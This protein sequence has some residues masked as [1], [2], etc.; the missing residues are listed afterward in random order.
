MFQMISIKRPVM[1]Q[2]LLS[3]MVWALPLNVIS[4]DLPCQEIEVSQSI[5]TRAAS[6]SLFDNWL[7][8]RGTVR[9]ESQLM[10]TQ[11]QQRLRTLLI[12]PKGCPKPCKISEKPQMTFESLP[13]KI[14]QGYS[15]SEKCES[16]F[17]KSKQDP[18]T[19]EHNFSA[20]DDLVS[21]VQELS[22]GNGVDGEDLY[23]RCDG[24]CSPRYYYSIDL[25]SRP[26]SIKAKI[27]CG[28]ARDKSENMYNISFGFSWICLS[29]GE[30]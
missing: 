21:W 12:P 19:Y 23:R 28:H 30:G 4:A 25:V 10:F 5:E 3:V 6:A 29:Q 7:N 24:A 13:S 9:R 16:Y 26:F 27:I 14:L 15:D 20:V 11:A 18:I 1:S 17:Q 8:L 22:K 2:W